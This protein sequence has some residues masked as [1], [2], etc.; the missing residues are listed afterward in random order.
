[1]E[2]SLVGAFKTQTHC[3]YNVKVLCEI[4]ENI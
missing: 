3:T 4:K 1:M 2:N